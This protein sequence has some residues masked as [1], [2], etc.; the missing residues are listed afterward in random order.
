MKQVNIPGQKGKAGAGIRNGISAVLIVKNEEKVL[1]RCL[2]SIDQVDEIVVLDTGST[3]RTVEIARSITSKVFRAPPIN[4]FHFGEARNLAL[5]YARHDWVLTIDADEIAHDGCIAEIRK[6]CWNRPR[7]SAFRVKFIVSSDGGENQASIPK[8]K[9]FRRTS[10]EWRYRIHEILVPRRLPATVEDLPEAVMEHLPPPE[11]EKTERRRQNL[12]LLQVS[13]KESPEYVRNARQ[14]G[15]EH[16]SREEYREAIPWLEMYVQSGTGGPLDQSETLIHLG[17]AHAK[18][19]LQEEA[20]RNFDRAIEQAP[21]RKEIYYHKALT[22]IS[23]ARP[24][25][26]IPI[27]EKGLAIPES[28]KPDFH[29]NVDRIW[30]GSYLQEALDFCRKTVEEHEKGVA[31]AS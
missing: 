20:L 21:V 29:L 26:A 8:M 24:D 6:A 10:W 27:L 4:P 13:V 22:L 5:S 3:D 2:R 25:L 18:V 31:G 28:A 17:R 7:V 9:V 11:A 23:G 14:L 15:M 1:E 30:D 12:E 19:G 16:F